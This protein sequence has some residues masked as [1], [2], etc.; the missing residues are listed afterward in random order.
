[1]L[2]DL[3][4]ALD[5]VILSSSAAHQNQMM[6]LLSDPNKAQQFSRIIFNLLVGGCD[7]STVK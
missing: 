5:D 3:P 4:K 1:M 7:G 6:Q 2:G